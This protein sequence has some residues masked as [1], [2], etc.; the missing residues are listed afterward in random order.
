MK[1]RI[2]KRESP[3]GETSFVIQQP[4]FLF[5]WWWVDAWCN[6]GP[7]CQDSF[8]TLTEAQKYLPFFDGTPWKEAI[9]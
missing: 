7:E 4:H 3:V 9:V 5:R 2:I 1:A 8:S 6:Q